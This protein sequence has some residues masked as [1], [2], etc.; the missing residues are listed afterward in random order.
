MM[1]DKLLSRLKDMRN[2]YTLIKKDYSVPHLVLNVSFSL[3]VEF[4]W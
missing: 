3:F 4:S 1:N 2:T